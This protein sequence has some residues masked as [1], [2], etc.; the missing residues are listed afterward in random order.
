VAFSFIG[1][2]N[3]STRRK[4]KDPGRFT[5]K[6]NSESLSHVL[7]LGLQFSLSDSLLYIAI[8]SVSTLITAVILCLDPLI[9][10]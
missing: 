4:L 1:G 7:L 8:M 10:V 3:Q 6:N 9:S 2:G 5:L